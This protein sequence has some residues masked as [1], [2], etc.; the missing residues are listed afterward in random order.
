MEGWHSPQEVAPRPIVVMRC[1]SM[2]FQGVHCMKTSLITLIPNVPEVSCRT[3]KKYQ[4][5]LSLWRRLGCPL[6]L[7]DIADEHFALFRIIALRK[8]LKPTTIN[9]TVRDVVALTKR[10]GAS[11]DAGET[12]KEL[13]VCKPVP[14]IDQISRAYEMAHT[15]RWPNCKGSKTPGLCR[16]TNGQFWQAF[17]L[18]IYYTGM[19]LEDA[20]DLKWQDIT[21]GSIQIVAKKTGKQHFWPLPSV[22]KDH[23]TSLREIGSEKVFGLPKWPF[24]RIR[25]ELVRLGGKGL[26]PQA[27]RRSAVTT[28]TEVN[29]TARLIIQGCGLGVTISYVDQ[30]RILKRLTP[31]F[32][33]PLAALPPEL[34]DAS[35]RCQAEIADILRT[36][37][38][39]ELQNVL[40]VARA[41]ARDPRLD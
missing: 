17:I 36:M 14:E 18:M 31:R 25:R 22:L 29:D 35:S 12:L 7:E 11:F 33:F 9:A 24:E 28:W 13:A 21:D 3:A 1:A 15:A 39:D 37:P 23:L 5:R 4:Y 6:E 2:N 27:L 41:F 34:R 30:L 19:R 20:H 8:R 38:A 32:P 16:I 10:G 40:R 26:T